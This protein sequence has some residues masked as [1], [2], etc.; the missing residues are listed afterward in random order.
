MSVA[1]I[2]FRKTSAR[3][4]VITKP[5]DRSVRACHGRGGGEQ[6][7]GIVSNERAHA[8]SASLAVLRRASRAAIQPVVYC[9]WPAFHDECAR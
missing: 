8:A 7:A 9:G 5:G 3:I 1:R 2:S 4:V 6:L